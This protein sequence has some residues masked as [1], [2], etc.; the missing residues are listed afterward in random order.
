MKIKHKVKK[1]VV[2][3]ALA[4]SVQTTSVQASGIPVVDIV[5]NIQMALEYIEAI[6]QTY[7][8]YTQILNEIDMIQNQLEQAEREVKNW[9][10]FSGSAFIKSEA[11]ALLDLKNASNR[12]NALAFSMGLT[13]AYSDYKNVTQWDALAS[14][15]KTIRADVEKRWNVQQ[16]ETAKSSAAVIDQASSALDDDRTKL[17]ALQT[18]YMAADGEMQ[19]QQASN[20]LLSMQNDQLIQTRT[21]MLNDQQMR[22]QEVARNAEQEAVIQARKKKELDG[23]N[24]YNPSSFQ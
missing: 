16:L 11:E 14:I 5:A 4:T 9:K 8:Q 15:T 3:L 18:K 7:Q 20:M 12:V 24:S 6:A 2:A 19:A 17:A 22:V 1:L 10:N 23:I 21:L 13:T